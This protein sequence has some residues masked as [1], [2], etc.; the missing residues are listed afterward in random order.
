MST[1]RVQAIPLCTAHEL[2]RDFSELIAA[3]GL[4]CDD[5]E[6]A[7]LWGAFT[8]G[9][10]DSLW[11]PNPPDESAAFISRLSQSAPTI[12]SV[13][14][15]SGSAIRAVST[16]LPAP[17][18]LTRNLRR[19]LQGDILAG[20]DHL[21]LAF[22]DRRRSCVGWV[23]DWPETASLL[24]Q[25]QRLSDENVSVLVCGDTGTGKEIVARALHTLG[26]RVR[27]PFFAINCAELPESILEGELFGHVRGAFTGATS[28][29][30]G[31]FE[32]SGDGTVFL[33]EIGE[34]PLA[35]QAKLLRVLEEHLVRRLGSTQ[36]RPLHCR[37]ITATNRDLSDEIAGGRF[38]RDL[39]YRL[40]G[41]ELRL[42]PLRERPRDILPLAEL[43]LTRAALRFRRGLVEL[44]ADAKLVLLSHRWPG[45]VRELRQVMEVAVLSASDTSISA[46]HLNLLRDP[47]ASPA[48]P[49]LTAGAVERAHIL[50]ALASTSGNKLAAARIL[51]LSRQ[52]LQRRMQRHGIT[53]LPESE[54]PQ[55]GTPSGN[56]ASGLVATAFNKQIS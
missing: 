51:G 10:L 38:R 45:N 22:D 4:F 42:R 18:P 32:A 2:R 52:S 6:A 12:H 1:P 47:T 39:F 24:D 54:C 28:D 56:G 46:D 7:A 21:I 50:R 55:M 33:D 3:A 19:L 41:S 36:P 16:E 27:R 53:S 25:L 20:A 34:L 40:R 13:L 35:A 17:D 43:F 9:P 15:V 14:L 30:I 29:R 37:I 26:R 49:L 5:A 44:S 8:E 23:G 31:L 48:M 11:A